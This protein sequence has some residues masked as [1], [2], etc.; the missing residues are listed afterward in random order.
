M[1]ETQCRID[2]CELGFEHEPLDTKAVVMSKILKELDI[3]YKMWYTRLSKKS[4]R[5]VRKPSIEW[6]DMN[7]V[8]ELDVDEDHAAYAVYLY[9]KRMNIIIMLN[10]SLQ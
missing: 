5:R 8:F 9:N 4:L 10:K 6:S 2:M 1:S 7:I 3:P